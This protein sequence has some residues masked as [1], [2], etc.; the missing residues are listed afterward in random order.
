MAAIITRRQF[1][2]G[3]VGL[4][5]GFVATQIFRDFR[6]RDFNKPRIEAYLSSV[7]PPKDLNE[8]PNII[9]L[10]DDLNYGNL[11]IY[12]ADAIQAP[13]IDQVAMLDEFNLHIE[14]NARSW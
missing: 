14:E 12:G 8:L 4:G 9:F 10:I 3:A 5:S 1:L 2:K 6:G 11:G 13:N 7:Q